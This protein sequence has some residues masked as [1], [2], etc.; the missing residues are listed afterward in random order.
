MYR[1]KAAPNISLEEKNMKKK[2]LTP[3]G[4]MVFLLLLSLG[5]G[6]MVY[7]YVNRNITQ[8]AYLDINHNDMGIILEDQP[9]QMTPAPLKQENVVYIPYSWAKTYVSD[10]IFLDQSEK[11]FTY[12]TREKL[13]RIEADEK[14]IEVDGEDADLRIPFKWLN[15]TMYIPVPFLET[16]FN[17]TFNY[18]E[19]LNMLLVNDTL[20]KQQ[21]AKV[22]RN[23]VRLHESMDK[24]SEV[25]L[26]LNKGE[27][28]VLYEQ[29]SNEEWVKVRVAKGTLGYMRRK[30][31]VDYEVKQ[32]EASKL[33]EVVMPERNEPITLVWHQV[34]NQ[35][36]NGR[37][38]M[39]FDNVKSL[40]VISPTWFSI[41]DEE[42][43]IKSIANS[44]YVDWAHGEGYEVWALIDNSFDGQLTHAI[45]ETSEKRQ[46]LIDQLIDY[47]TAYKL[48][49]VNIDFES[50]LK[51][52]GPYF[53]QF[54][55]ELGPQLR[56]IDVNLSIDVYVPSGWTQHYQRSDLARFADYIV[57]MGYDEHWSGS[58]EAGSVSSIG[59]VDRAIERTLEEVPADQIIMGVPFYTRLWKEETKDGEMSLSSQALS[60]E[61]ANNFISRNDIE[62]VWNEETAQNYGQLDLENITY[63]IWLEDYKSLSFKLNLIKK[64]DLAG[65]AAWKKNLETDDIWDLVEGTFKV[66]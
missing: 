30:Y 46:V 41:I 43:T 6:A 8:I 56:S 12:A 66:E 50:I 17:V 36:A 63:K 19:E 47:A 1:Q 10:D 16:Y 7:F 57:V 9:M 49:G 34:F 44:S 51:E 24:K 37:V 61:K 60:M 62:T 25:E 22:K 58:K 3:K 64:A 55:K 32:A 2:R 15:N 23:R 38:A 59:F 11:I 13:Y 26:L 53:V 5:I 40:D 14:I 29:D 31:L 27:E 35:T 4:V 45:L 33:K 28:V 20:K 21:L 18:A 54:I 65:M 52:T 42:G 39:S 48:D